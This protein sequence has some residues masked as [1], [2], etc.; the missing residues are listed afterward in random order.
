M[1][2][3]AGMLS[4]PEGAFRH[5]HMPYCYSGYLRYS[6]FGFNPRNAGAQIHRLA[7]RK[8][9]I[10]GIS[11]GCKAIAYSATSANRRCFINPMTHYITL[12][13]RYQTL[14]RFW[15]PIAEVL[16]YALG[17]LSFIPFIKTATGDHYSLALL[18][19]QLFW[20]GYGDPSYDK[21][22]DMSLTGVILSADDE[23][24]DN[25]I[26]DSIYRNSYETSEIRTRHADTLSP[27]VAQEYEDAMCSILD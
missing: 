23:Y 4:Q 21:I 2:L 14:I 12:K 27:H 5:I 20:T 13:P 19:D 10:V 8:D 16:S 11:I 9:Y 17:W 24:L 22:K 18:V 26:V 7:K 3:I 6:C 25:T 15:T 1:I